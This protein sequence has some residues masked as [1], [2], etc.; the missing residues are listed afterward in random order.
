M[1]SRSFLFRISFHFISFHPI[2]TFWGIDAWG[3]CH[4]CAV[5]VPNRPPHETQSQ[6]LWAQFSGKAIVILIIPRL[7]CVANS[8]AK[9][10]PLKTNTNWD[11]RIAET[12]RDYPA[13]TPRLV[14]RKALDYKDNAERRL[15][16]L[17]ARRRRSSWANFKISG[18]LS[19]NTA[20]V[21]RSSYFRMY[22]N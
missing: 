21:H 18:A 11:P 7:G 19:M 6:P 15:I 4:C 10:I 2:T 13:S 8:L 12:L 22:R 3:S 9:A 1:F 16:D 5:G 14:L 17:A 20:M